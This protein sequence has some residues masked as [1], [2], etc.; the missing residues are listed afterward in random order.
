MHTVKTNAL[1]LR[2]GTTTRSLEVVSLF[3]NVSLIETI[4]MIANGVKDSTIPQPN[5][6]NLF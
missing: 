2:A 5:M 6:L 3:T 4:Q 1:N